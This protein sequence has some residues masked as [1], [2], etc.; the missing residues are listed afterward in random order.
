MRVMRARRYLSTISSLPT[1][2]PFLEALR[3]PE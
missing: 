3:E 2:A 1:N